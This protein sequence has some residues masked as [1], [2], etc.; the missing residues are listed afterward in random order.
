[1]YWI[2]SVTLESHTK[3][4]IGYSNLALLSELPLDVRCSTVLHRT[5]LS[6]K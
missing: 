5:L 1:M 4:M 2:L 6:E 3:T